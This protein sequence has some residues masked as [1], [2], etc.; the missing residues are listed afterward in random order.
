MNTYGLLGIAAHI[1][2]FIHSSLTILHK[3]DLCQQS[4]AA[5]PAGRRT[6]HPGSHRSTSLI[7]PGDDKT[8]GSNAVEEF[9]RVDPDLTSD[10]TSDGRQNA[11]YICSRCS[12]VPRRRALHT[13]LAK[14][15]G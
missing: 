4:F 13:Q 1:Y 5:D 3:Y 10:L 7:D 11:A 9:R 12:L 15:V 14:K 8:R 2:P 6:T